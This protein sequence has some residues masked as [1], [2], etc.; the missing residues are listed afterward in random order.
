MRILVKK[1]GKKE[2]K[3]DDFS[4]ERM[5]QECLYPFSLGNQSLE[6]L[7]EKEV[8]K[9]RKKKLSPSVTPLRN[10]YSSFWMLSTTGSN[11]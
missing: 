10:S 8:E 11:D 3:G 5:G 4:K 1:G 2:A 6:A 9:I 7:D